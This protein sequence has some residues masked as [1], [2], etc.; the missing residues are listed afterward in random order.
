MA[1]F[2]S[3]ILTTGTHTTV[4]G[5][6]TAIIPP[7]DVQHEDRISFQFYNPNGTASHIDTLKVYGRLGTTSGTLGATSEW[8]QIGDNVVVSGAQSSLKSIATT[9][10][11]WCGVTIAPSGTVDAFDDHTYAMLRQT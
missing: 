8:T 6:D 9:G 2:K 1:N 10:L 4:T 11:N 5:Q 3:A 7:V